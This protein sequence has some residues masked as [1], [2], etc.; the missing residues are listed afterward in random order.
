MAWSIRNY[1]AFIRAARKKSDLTRGQA[2][3][4]YRQMSQHLGR[5]LQGVDVA[6]HPRIFK[7]SERVATGAAHSISRVT[8]REKTRVASGKGGSSGGTVGSLRQWE[9]RIRDYDSF[10]DYDY[11]EYESSA[12]Y[13]EV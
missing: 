13:G 1:N 3:N 4:V 11:D 6:K 5:K 9:N 7:K 2:R 8:S 10:A 12:D